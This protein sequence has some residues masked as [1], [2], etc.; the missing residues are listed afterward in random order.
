MDRTARLR[1][2]VARA[3]TL[4]FY[5]ERL[6][7]L[8]PE[9]VS[10]EDVS[11]LPFVTREELTAAFKTDPHGGFLAP[12]I[13]Q[14]H[15]TPAPE[16]GRM[17]EYLTQ[18]DVAWQAEAAAAQLE[19]C[20]LSD[21]DRC[22]VVFSYH[23]LAGGWLFHEGLTKLGATVLALGPADAAQVVDIAQ[24]YGFNVLVSNPS[25][26]RKLGEAG[27]RFDKLVAAGEP[28]SAVPG[29][30]EGVEAALGCEAYDAYGLSETGV[31]AA[32]TVV[33]DG[34]HSVAEAAVLEVLDP[35]TLQEVADGDK[36]ELVVTSLTREGMPVLR[37]RTGDLT[38]KGSQDGTLVLPRG[39]FGRTDTMVKIK[40]VKVYPKELLFILAATPG[41]NFRN[42]QLELSSRP[43][44]TD[45]VVLHLEHEA[46]TDPANIDTTELGKRVRNATGVGMNEIRLEPSV[47]GDLVVDKRF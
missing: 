10:A 37:F 31:V 38:L 2:I 35:Q 43:D 5:R 12:D 41:L 25:F 21:D 22:L 32:E 19:R 6:Q 4:P 44:G 24:T 27:G 28:F 18:N 3:K 40:G 11:A 17:P 8:Q 7:E 20:G 13:V 33:K 29:Y 9:E 15:L 26:A 14:M 36:G 46:D 30:R 1:H 34:L 45:Q 42:Y 16:I 47:T 23:M 39:V